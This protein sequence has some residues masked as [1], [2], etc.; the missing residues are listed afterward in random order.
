MASAIDVAVFTAHRAAVSVQVYVVT[1]ILSIHRLGG[2]YQI[3]T[4]PL[5][6]VCRRSLCGVK[7]RRI[8]NRRTAHDLDNVAIREYLRRRFDS[9]FINTEIGK[10]E[11]YRV[12]EQ[13]RLP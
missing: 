9:R 4:A 13:M 5:S 1:S 7:A 11:W 10:E 12:T 2:E 8:F 6:F 3:Q